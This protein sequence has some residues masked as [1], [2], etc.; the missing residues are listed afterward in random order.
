MCFGFAV[1][2][3]DFTVQKANLCLIQH[4]S[5]LKGYVSD[6]QCPA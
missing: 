1:G 4:I 3:C 5:K 2:I 6:A